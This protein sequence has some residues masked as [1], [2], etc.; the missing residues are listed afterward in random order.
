MKLRI[1][2]DSK[3]DRCWVLARVHGKRSQHAHF[4]SKK[5]A[6]QCRRIIDNQQYPR[7]KKYIKAVQRILTMA[8]IKKLNKTPRYCNKQNGKRR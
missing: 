2:Y 4:Y 7:E 3:T 6:L 5:E 8:E 1:G